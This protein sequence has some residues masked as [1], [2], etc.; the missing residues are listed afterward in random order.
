[1]K[2]YDKDND[3]KHYSNRGFDIRVG[4]KCYDKDND[5]KHY[6]NRGFDIRVG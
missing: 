6:S 1:M 4:M 3:K 2:C 5:K